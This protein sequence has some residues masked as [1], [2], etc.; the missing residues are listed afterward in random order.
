MSRIFLAVLIIIVGAISAFAQKRSTVMGD[1]WVGEVVST[2]EATREITLKSTE[3]VKTETF[4][5]VLREGYTVTRRDGSVQE[6][7][8]S[9][10]VPGSRVRVFY[11]TDNQ[12]I[13][14][15]KVKIYKISQIDFLGRDEY[16]RLRESLNLDAATPVILAKSDN[17]P[18]ITPLKIHLAIDIPHLSERFVYWVIEWN[19]EKATKHGPLELVDNPATSDIALVVYRGS[20]KIVAPYLQFLGSDSSTKLFPVTAYIVINSHAPLKVL[21]TQIVVLS[22]EERVGITRGFLEKEIEKRMKARQQAQ[23]K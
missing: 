19:K 10:I 9:E 14:G 20:E 16:A 21:W 22:S 8:L 23:K 2:N 15:R 4:V 18:A 11:K 17:L 6:L 7:R 1:A 12:D 13:G 3:N 5:A